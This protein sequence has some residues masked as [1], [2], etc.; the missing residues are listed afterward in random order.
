MTDEIERLFL[1][2]DRAQILSNGDECTG[3]NLWDDVKREVRAAM[4]DKDARIAELESHWPKWA[5]SIL[6][7]LQDFG[8]RFDDLIDLPEE[9][10]N[11]LNEYPDSAVD[12]LCEERDQLRAENERLRNALKKIADGNGIYG[13]QAGEYKGIARAALQRKAGE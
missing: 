1:E 9:L 3:Q 8:W 12:G 13:I 11:Y 2:M 4:Q 7:T 6:S 5:R 10:E